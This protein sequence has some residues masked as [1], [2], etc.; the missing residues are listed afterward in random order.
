MQH[1][2]VSS[3]E[4]QG[5]HPRVNVCLQLRTSRPSITSFFLLPSSSFLPSSF[6]PSALA[7]FGSR[8]LV[9]SFRKLTTADVDAIDD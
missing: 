9:L 3:T 5:T 4:A 1:A 8:V 6:P 7:F 2:T